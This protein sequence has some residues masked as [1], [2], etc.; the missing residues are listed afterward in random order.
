VKS[1]G[2]PLWA[3]S[4]RHPLFHQLLAKLKESQQSEEGDQKRLFSGA[5]MFLL[6]EQLCALTEPIEART[7]DDLIHPA[8]L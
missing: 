6:M 8:I 3:D 1:G 7:F 4:T 2:A 5:L